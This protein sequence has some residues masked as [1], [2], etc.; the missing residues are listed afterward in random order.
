[1]EQ[2]R[3]A[4]GDVRYWNGSSFPFVRLTC[5]SPTNA[6][7]FRLLLS[8]P[9]TVSATTTSSL[10]SPLVRMVVRLLFLFSFS[11]LRSLTRHTS[12]SQYSRRRR[13]CH[14]P[15]D[16][17]PPD[18]CD[19][20][21]LVLRGLNLPPVP[22]RKTAPQSILYISASLSLVR[23]LS[24]LRVV[25]RPCHPVVPAVLPSLLPLCREGGKRKRKRS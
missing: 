10:R 11:L 25:E 18:W 24:I 9:S 3:L 14:A 5:F 22:P 21:G 6:F 8:P 2:G 4:E 15:R 16:R 7:L 1:V 17:R 20:V 19:Q 12:P 23:T 13:P